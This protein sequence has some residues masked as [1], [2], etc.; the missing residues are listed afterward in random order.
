VYEIVAAHGGR[1]TAANGPRG[2]AVVRV[3]LPCPPG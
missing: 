2:G 3:E 1:A